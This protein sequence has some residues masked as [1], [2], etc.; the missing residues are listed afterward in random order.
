MCSEQGLTV[1][2]CLTRGDTVE[3][4]VLILSC[5]PRSAGNSDAM[6]QHVAQ[7]VTAAGGQ[8]RILYLRDYAITP[9]TGCHACFAHEHS[10]CVFEHKDHASELLALLA[11]DAPVCMVSPIYFYHVPALL[12]ALLDRGQKF[13]AKRHKEEQAQGGIAQQKTGTWQKNAAIALVA[14][15]P[16]GENLFTGSLLSLSLFWDVLQRNV[17]ITSLWKGYDGP[18]AFAQDAQAC[19]QMQ[20][21]GK[22]LASGI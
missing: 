22:Q 5:S 17:G 2:P 9:C 4:T 6:A 7:G 20:E 15:R 16:R 21:L 12:K 1:L 3:N 18:Q 11:G 14:A 10:H 8:A 19:A 13:W